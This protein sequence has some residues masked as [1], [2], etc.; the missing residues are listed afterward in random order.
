MPVI[1]ATQEAEI[2]RLVGGL[3]PALGKSLRP[4]VKLTK[5]KEDSDMAQVV[6]HLPRKFEALS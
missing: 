5:S 1:T 4:Y 2:G 3:Q 6:E